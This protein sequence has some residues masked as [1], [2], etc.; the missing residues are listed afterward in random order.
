MILTLTL[1]SAV[2]LAQSLPNKQ[3]SMEGPATG[4]GVGAVVG[5]PSGLAVSW[6]PTPT[7]AI[8]AATGFSGQQGRF[9]LNADYIHTVWAFFSGDGSWILPVYVGGGVRYRTAANDNDQR[10][11]D[12]SGFG[13]RLPV[14]LRVY[15]EDVRLDIF[16][17]GAPAVH[18]MPAPTFA[19]DFG[20][21]VR[22][23]AGG[24]EG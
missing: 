17:E 7:K 22:L 1:V 3:D 19:V 13:V 18:F 11:A 16:V 12:Q 14:G 2:S 21:G 8:Q 5:T 15:P 24:T 9:A 23:W 4:V 20:I 6:R 10:V